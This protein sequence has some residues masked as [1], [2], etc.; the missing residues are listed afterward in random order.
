VEKA[1]EILGVTDVTVEMVVDM[2]NNPKGGMF[3]HDTDT[4]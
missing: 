1:K 2:L 4:F 3:Q